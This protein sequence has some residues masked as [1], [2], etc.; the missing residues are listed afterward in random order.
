MLLDGAPWLDGTEALSE[1]LGPEL[2]AE[3]A[4]A[5]GIGSSKVQEFVERYNTLVQSHVN[6]HALRQSEAYLAIGVA[7]APH[8]RADAFGEGDYWLVC[9]SFSTRTPVIVVFDEF[10]L[11]IAALTKLQHLINQYN[12]VFSELRINTDYGEELVTLRPT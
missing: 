6:P 5:F 10:R 12:G 8:G 7:L 2:L 3:E 1:E 9:D 11:P 4:S